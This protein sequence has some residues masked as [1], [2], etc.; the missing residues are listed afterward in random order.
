MTLPSGIEL[1]LEE[2]ADGGTVA[3][4]LAVDDG[5]GAVVTADVAAAAAA[6]PPEEL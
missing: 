6:V 5:T 1:P 2:V 4:A 3:D